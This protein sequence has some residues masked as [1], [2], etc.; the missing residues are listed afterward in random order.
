MRIDRSTIA[1]ASLLASLLATTALLVVDPVLPG[2]L[3]GRIAILGLAAFAWVASLVAAGR[4]ALA[5]RTARERRLQGL[6]RAG[7]ALAIVGVDADGR[8]DEWSAGAARLFGR[9]A[10]EALGN[11]FALG[12]AEAALERGTIDSALR[13]AREQ[14][15]ADLDGWCV[16]RDGS[17]FWARA[18]LV[19]IPDAAVAAAPRIAVIALDAT[20][21]RRGEDEAAEARERLRE[22]AEMTADY[23]YL[24]IEK[25]DGQLVVDWQTG[26]LEGVTG[27]T[28]DGIDP[29][30]GGLGLA[31]PE[32]VDLAV[33]H[34][35]RLLAREADTAEFRVVSQA[36]DIRWVREIGRPRW[37]ADRNELRILCAVRD[38]TARKTIE[39][40]S[41]RK[42]AELTRTLNAATVAELISGLKHDLRQPLAAI[43]NYARGS[44]RRLRSGTIEPAALLPPL[45]EIA[46]LAMAADGVLVQLQGVSRD[47]LPEVEPMAVEPAL[48]ETIDLL[49][50]DIARLGVEVALDVPAGLPIALADRARFEQVI[51]QLMRNALQAL[52]S[53]ERAHR[54]VA[55][56]ARAVDDGLEVLVTD[57]GR[58]I[59]PAS[60]A[61]LFRPFFTTKPGALGLG[62]VIARSIVHSI[63]GGL[64]VEPAPGGGTTARFTIPRATSPGRD[65]PARWP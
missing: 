49:A 15:A 46:G 12:H 24:L 3:P 60:S 6:L 8:I 44:I 23:A 30:R 32:D 20:A 26:G 25:P 52:E 38:I 62:L 22:L 65:T 54:R 36:G 39:A 51:L 41:R 29:R 14:G 50:D 34:R 21:A 59:A 43:V 2:P 10:E 42:S 56:S 19:R 4:A 48:R 5:E 27:R 47:T 35:R 16:R 1:L 17:R 58:G 57:S 53:V 28:T 45:E 64:R 18:R 63:G 37:D 13:T 11:P 33:R 31:H 9:S 61:M 7:D 55:I 40:R